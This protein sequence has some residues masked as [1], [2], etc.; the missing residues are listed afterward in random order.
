M[1]S[2]VETRLRLLG[3]CEGWSFVVL[4][5]VAMPL[6]YLFQRP[7]AVRVVGSIH[8]GLFVL[9][10]LAVLVV[11]ALHRWHL[12]RTFLALVASVIPFGPFL[13]DGRLKREAEIAV[14]N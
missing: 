7:E 2:P 14:K 1:N 6:K 10:V 12:R 11:A 5:L 8:G 3:L 4:V 9:Y 13:L